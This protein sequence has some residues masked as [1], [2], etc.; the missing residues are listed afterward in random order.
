MKP[1]LWKTK[2][3]DFSASQAFLVS[4]AA[5]DSDTR[6][7]SVVHYFCTGVCTIKLVHIQ[8]MCIIISE[9][10]A[11]YDRFCGQKL[12]LSSLSLSILAA[13]EDFIL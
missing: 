6:V 8:Y 13:D 11:F 2:D 5:A 7:L 12:T 3:A 10:V 9:K 1:R 4:A